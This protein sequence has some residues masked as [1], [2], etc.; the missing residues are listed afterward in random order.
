MDLYRDLIP[1]L[2]LDIGDGRATTIN[3]KSM[4]ISKENVNIKKILLHSLKNEQ[5]EN[6]YRLIMRNKELYDSY[7]DEEVIVEL[8]DEKYVI[9]PETYYI[10]IF[11][12]LLQE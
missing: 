6:K 2:D 10:L 9:S 11:N 1:K 4:L 3:N 5:F 12:C 7:E 8:E